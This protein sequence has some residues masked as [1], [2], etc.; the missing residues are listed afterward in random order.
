MTAVLQ[1]SKWEVLA[2]Q[3]LMYC[4]FLPTFSAEKGITKLLEKNCGF[5]SLA[6]HASYVEIS[7]C[8]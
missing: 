2:E 8:V 1:G 7:K 5:F 3:N 6:I 4:Q